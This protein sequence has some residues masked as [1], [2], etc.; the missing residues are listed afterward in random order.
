MGNDTFYDISCRNLNYFIVN[1][2][3]YSQL[4]TKRWTNLCLFAIMNNSKKTRNTSFSQNL[5]P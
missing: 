5:S 1:R 2:Y 4:N 3:A